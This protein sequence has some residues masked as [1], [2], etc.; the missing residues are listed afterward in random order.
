MTAASTG[1]GASTTAFSG[2]SLVTESSR[3]LDL[4]SLGLVL[5]LG[6]AG[7]N[8]MA[9]T[10]VRGMA[11]L[12]DFVVMTFVTVDVVGGWTELGV[13]GVVDAVASDGTSCVEGVSD[14]VDGG[15]IVEGFRVGEALGV[16]AAT[17]DA[18]VVGVGTSTSDV[19]SVCAS[20]L[21]TSAV[22]SCGFCGSSTFLLL[23]SST[24]R[25]LLDL[26]LFVGNGASGRESQ[27]SWIMMVSRVP[28]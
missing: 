24:G 15:S 22:T 28:G 8:G 3:G 5:A 1:E 6:N 4:G 7:I 10:A 21:D 25:L 16:E 9:G 17:F 19:V 14:R 18:V 26:A 11:G 13:V 27:G 12:E 23:L 2:S 20:W